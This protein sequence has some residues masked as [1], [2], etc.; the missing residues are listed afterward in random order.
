MC[1]R[2]VGDGDKLL[3][4]PKFLLATIA[5]FLPHLG[6]GYSTVGYWGPKTLCL[7]PALTTAS[8]P[9][10]NQPV[11]GQVILMFSSTC[12]RC[13][14][15]FLDWRLGRGSIYNTSSKSRRSLI[16]TFRIIPLRKLC[17]SLS[18]LSFS[19]RNICYFKVK[20]LE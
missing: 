17:T 19:Y 3:Y 7:P 16:F 11:C 13:S 6:R 1:G 20:M 4:W 10:L 12:F 5:A 8:S 18:D 9:L 14:S 2:W 15:V